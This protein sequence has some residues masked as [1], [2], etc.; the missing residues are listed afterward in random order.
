[1]SNT[2]VNNFFDN[3]FEISLG[4]GLSLQPRS[5]FNEIPQDGMFTV[6]EDGDYVPVEDPITI[7]DPYYEEDGTDI[8]IKTLI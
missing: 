2:T 6:D 1:M 7:D 5:H 3:L 4:N 8:T